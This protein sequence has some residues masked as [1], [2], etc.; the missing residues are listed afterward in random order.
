MFKSLF[1]LMKEQPQ[2]ERTANIL[3]LWTSTARKTEL[4]RLLSGKGV[5]IKNVIPSYCTPSELEEAPGVQLNIVLD[6]Y[7]LSLARMM[8]EKFGTNYI[9]CRKPYHPDSIEE[10]YQNI[11]SALNVDLPVEVADLKKKTEAQQEKAR[12][13]LSGMTCAVFGTSG[14]PFDLAHLL[15]NIGIEPRA[16]LLQTIQPEDRPDIQSLLNA[17][18]DPIVFRGDNSLQNEELLAELSPDISV[19]AFERSSLARMGIRPIVLSTSNYLLG[20]DSTLEVLRLIM[21][22]P[23]GLEALMFKEKILAG[24]E[25]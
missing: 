19:G 7:G 10:W 14:R 3:G 25:C 20:F 18:F 1:E 8:K 15:A 9:Y 13:A 21:E 23:P 11:A 17:G 5:R 22:K 24:G 12:A 16:M 2:E 4:V 6:Q